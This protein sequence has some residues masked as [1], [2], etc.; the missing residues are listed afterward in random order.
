MPSNEPKIYY[1]SLRDE[2]PCKDYWDYGILDLLNYPSEDV[3]KL[4]KTD[5]A[6]VVLPARHHAGYE[7]AVNHQL[8]RINKVVLF[9][10]GDEEADFDVSKIDHGDIQIWVQNPH[11]GIHDQYHKIGTGYTPQSQTILPT[12]KPKKTR[13]VFFAGQITHQRRE[14]LQR[15]LEHYKKYSGG[16][17][18]SVY[19]EGFTQGLKPDD[20]YKGMA[21]AIVAPAPSGAVIPDS[22]RLFEA[23]ES[24]AIP[25]ADEKCADGSTMDYWDWLFN[26]AVPFPKVID[27]DRLPTIVAEILADY[28]R[29]L[30]HQT[31]WW[32]QKKR[33]FKWKVREQLGLEPQPITVIIPTSV[34]P[35]HPSTEIIDETI[36]GI[37]AHLPDAEIIM[38]IDGLRD[39][40]SDRQDAYDLYKTR[41]LWKCLHEWKNVTPVV[42]DGLHHQTDMLRATIDLVKTPLLLY[43]EGDAPLTPDRP[44]DW[45]LCIDKILSG[46][47]NTVR[48]HHENVIPLE[49][50]DLMLGPVEDDFRKTYQ[51]SQRPHLSSTVYYKDTVIPTLPDTTFIEDSF[52]GVV[53][54][55]WFQSG[56]LGWYKHR[57]WIYHPHNGIQR[58]YTTDGRS[59]GLKFTSDDEVGL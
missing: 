2:T 9:L 10:M 41:V 47:A 27:W 32:L 15:V 21:G 28:P 18:S 52:H 26:E 51:W 29:N 22:F 58:S 53:A 31:A 56:M 25:I 17:V 34:L 33:E 50:E 5:T 36:A 55:D 7:D 48:F 12:L 3:R 45:Q 42:F 23:L 8:K 40:Q 39:E 1:L 54:N 43:V 20:Y 38:Q 4:P 14:E 57:L 19:T 30:H 37:R 35:S 24:M 49:H 59:G 6:I 11:P 46:E 13:T 16:D 44:I